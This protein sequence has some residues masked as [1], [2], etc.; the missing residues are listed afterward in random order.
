MSCKHNDL[1]ECQDC[2]MS[3][4][5]AELTRLRAKLSEAQASDD[6][7]ASE[8]ETAAYV[9]VHELEVK[10]AERDAMLAECSNMLNYAVCPECANSGFTVVI[11]TRAV[12]GCCGKFL[13][14]GECC[15]E[16][17]PVPEQYEKQVQC[18]WCAMRASLHATAQAN[19]KIITAA[20]DQERTQSQM[21]DYPDEISREY[22]LACGATNEAVREKK[23]LK[24]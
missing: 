7:A 24:P 4:M 22:V 16:A 12:P 6:K 17:I 19:A 14:S 1:Y 2:A 13:S 20:E 11:E 18:D 9:R 5:A 15:G 23:E 21:G 3:R 10:L 8:A